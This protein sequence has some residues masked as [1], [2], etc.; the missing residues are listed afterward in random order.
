V[1]D[2]YD[3]VADRIR[4]DSVKDLSI[5]TLNKAAKYSHELQSVFESKKINPDVKKNFDPAFKKMYQEVRR[6]G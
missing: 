2:V 5:N 1:R 4:S 3:N 6:P